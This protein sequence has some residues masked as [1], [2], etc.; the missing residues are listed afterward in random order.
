MSIIRKIVVKTCATCNPKN[1]LGNKPDGTVLEQ[2]WDFCPVAQEV[3]YCGDKGDQVCNGW[4]PPHVKTDREK[5][6]EKL[7]HEERVTLGLENA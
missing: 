7:T 2:G 1:K 4:E 6:L 3:L 5:A